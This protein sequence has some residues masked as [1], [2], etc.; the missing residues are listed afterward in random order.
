MALVGLTT[1][2]PIEVVYAAGHTPIDLNNLF[3]SH[4]DPY[5]L[6]ASAEADG[7][8]RSL[9]AW[10]KGIYAVLAERP[11]IRLLIAVTQGD[12]S[13]THA[14][15][16]V[17]SGRGVE[18]VRFDYPPDHDPELLKRQIEK[19]VRFFGTSWAEAHNIRDRLAPIRARLRDLDELT[20]ANN[21]VTG[22]ENHLW[23]IQSSDF[24]GRPDRFAAEL[25]AFLD[26][27]ARRPALQQ[28]VRLGLAGIPPI[29]DGFYDA[30]EELGGRVVFNEIQRQF[31]MPDPGA[32]LVE[33]YLNYTYPY[34][35][36][37]RIED[38]AGQASR[39][40]LDGLIHYT[41]TFCFRQVQDI[42]LRQRLDLPILTVEGDRPGRL[43]AR[44]R[45]RLEAFVDVLRD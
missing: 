7:F 12:C 44:T 40:G 41:Q 19:L 17:L 22:W 43:D 23:L 14:L 36:F 32:D 42:V 25:E 11:D 33:Q 31:A 6:V 38:I 26:Q 27:A 8:A 16:E 20:W 10:I 1:S 15:V 2:V 18:V 3:I 37:G 34:D 21:Q 39:R 35:V 28:K 13:N 24:N 9:C 5:A 30:V 45:M 29:I 4:P